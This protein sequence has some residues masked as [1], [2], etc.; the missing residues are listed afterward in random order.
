[1][2]IQN[3]IPDPAKKCRVNACFAM[4]KRPCPMEPCEKHNSSLFTLP[5]YP[6]IAFFIWQPHSYK[7]E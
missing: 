3:L 7:G 5:L 2:R 4:G 1:A 6:D